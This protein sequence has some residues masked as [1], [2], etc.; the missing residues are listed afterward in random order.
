[1]KNWEKS[2]RT[3][4]TERLDKDFGAFTL[5]AS[6]TYSGTYADGGG[7]A[8]RKI[9][10]IYDKWNVCVLWN[11]EMASIEGEGRLTEKTLKRKAMSFLKKTLADLKHDT[12][13]ALAQLPKE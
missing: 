8:D 9:E 5:T 10:Y 6:N 1:M 13:E 2:A 12:T 4:T 7:C 11:D 3:E